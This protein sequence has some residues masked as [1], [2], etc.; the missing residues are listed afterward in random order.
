[1]TEAEAVVEEG[2]GGEEKRFDTTPVTSNL[3]SI[4]LNADEASPTMTTTTGKDD[5]K[6]DSKENAAE[7]QR[8]VRF[9]E[10]Q[11]SFSSEEDTDGL[12]EKLRS[13][14]TQAQVDLSGEKAI[15][16]R[17]EKNLVKLA[18]ELSHRQTEA[19]LKDRKIKQLEGRIDET[20]KLLE[21][22]KRDVED[23]AQKHRAAV[24]ENDALVTELE[25]TVRSLRKELFESNLERD[26]LRAT[27]GAGELVQSAVAEKS[28]LSSSVSRLTVKRIMIAAALGA[29]VAAAVFGVPNAVCAPVR[30]GRKLTPDADSVF[31]APW[32]APSPV[33]EV[34]FAAV[35]GSRTRTRL[36][37][38][39]DRLSVHTLTGNGE[40][41][42][43]W[44]GRASG[45]VRVSSDRISLQSKKGSIERVRAPWSA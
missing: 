19:E 20:E 13:Q 11:L 43:L 12:I 17:K 8:T 33:K 35:C 24:R 27:S 3:S 1:M 10:I 42:T 28:A 39:G 41:S 31:E 23:A 18:K 25:Q 6:G 44:Q 29:A 32:W 36:T 30:P 5:G 2:G 26:R 9:S 34:A 40:A 16:R 15:R 14:L 7:N 45:G 4:L 37:W 38:N 21:E 22:M